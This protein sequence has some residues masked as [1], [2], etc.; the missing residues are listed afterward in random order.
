[1]PRFCE[2]NVIPGANVNSQFG[3]AVCEIAGVSWVAVYHSINSHEYPCPAGGILEAVNPAAV[4][5]RL[6]DPHELTVAYG[7]QWRQRKCCR[8]SE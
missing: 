8:G 1:M 4:F 7:L 6:L 5:F 2:V 3:N